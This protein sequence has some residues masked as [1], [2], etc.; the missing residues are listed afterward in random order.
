Q[1]IGFT[2]A[3][4]LDTATLKTFVG[5]DNGYVTIWY[6]QSGNQ[7][8]AS[9]VY[10]FLTGPLIVNNGVINTTARNR[11]AAVFSSAYTS[12]SAAAIFQPLAAHTLNGVSAA[13]NGSMVSLSAIAGGAGF[14]STLGIS[15]EINTA[16]WFGGWGQDYAYN[17]GTYTPGQNV[18]TKTNTP[19][20]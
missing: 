16:G 3:G 11:P 8:N 20:A 18:L 7:N 1:D 5:T 13:N 10:S 19:G 9:P 4:D 17:A 2:P 15:E 12:L 14:N 6:D